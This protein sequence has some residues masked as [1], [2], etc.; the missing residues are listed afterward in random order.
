MPYASAEVKARVLEF[1]AD[2][3]VPVRVVDLAIDA[4]LSPTQTWK[5]LTSLVAEAK[6][7]RVSPRPWT[8]RSAAGSCGIR[9]SRS[10]LYRLAEPEGE[11]RAMGGEEH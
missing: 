8:F 7:E 9:L 4:G 3:D 11:V 2:R 10:N 6:V 1:L 5:A